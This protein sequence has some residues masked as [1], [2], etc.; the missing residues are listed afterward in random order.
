MSRRGHVI[1]THDANRLFGEPLPF[2]ILTTLK[3]CRR[4]DETLLDTAQRL[5]IREALIR[6]KG[7]ANGAANLLHIS[8]RQMSYQVQI[9]NKQGE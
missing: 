1:S 4:R 8:P 5:L 7:H 6:S 2:A 3:E 9:A